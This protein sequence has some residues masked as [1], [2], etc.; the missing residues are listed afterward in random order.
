ML[1]DVK[2][3]AFHGDQIEIVVLQLCKKT[4]AFHGH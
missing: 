4:S 3:S 1:S 2:I